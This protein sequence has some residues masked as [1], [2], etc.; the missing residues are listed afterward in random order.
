MPNIVDVDIDLNR[1][2][3][4]NILWDFCIATHG[5]TFS[6]PDDD[7]KQTE[8]LRYCRYSMAFYL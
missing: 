3:A 7:D 4:L 8:K 1:V 6:V 2:H 5:F